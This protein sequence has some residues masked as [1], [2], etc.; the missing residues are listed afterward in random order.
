MINEEAWDASYCH[1]PGDMMYALA[2][3]GKKS[4]DI[5]EI[6]EKTAYLYEHLD[7]MVEKL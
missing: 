1:L 6:S 5:L 7:L 2:R 4:E 3:S